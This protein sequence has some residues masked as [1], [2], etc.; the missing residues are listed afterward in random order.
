MSRPAVP[1]AAALDAA[2]AHW[3]LQ[4][5]PVAPVTGGLINHTF[6]VEGPDGP[7][8]LQQLHPVFAPEVHRNI[9]AVTAR[10]QE[11][12]VDTPALV[13]TR[14]GA[15]WATPAG[16]GGAAPA[17]AS[18]RAPAGVWRVLTYREGAC[19]ER[20]EDPRQARAAGA[21]LGEFH[22]ALADLDHTFEGV[23]AGV[24]DTQAHLR[25]LLD[26]TATHRDHRLH[27]EV[28]PMAHAIFAAAALLPALDGVPQRVVHGDPKFA[29][30]RFAGRDA[31]GRVAARC[32]LDLDTVGRMP[33]HFELGDAWRSWANVA[34]EDEPQA[35]F[36]LAVFEASWAGYAGAAGESVSAAERE[37][38]LYGV[39]WVT[40]ELTARFAAD[41][42]REDYF[43]WDSSRFPAAGE[44]NLRRAQG[45]WSLHTA[46]VATRSARARVLGL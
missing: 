14:D 10:L 13:P 19:F 16:P 20:V 28:L 8:I 1:T 7:V 11:R 25:R 30:I 31:A 42:L 3:G 46:T 23:R 24:H 34:G 27:D 40:L 37:A 12:G 15:L 41:A 33:L 22:R 9:A 39:E 35:Q 26:A 6:R 32:M 36:D 17:A 43:G 45:Q 4:G 21:L 44:H 38:L 2:L 18:E 5:R 29:N